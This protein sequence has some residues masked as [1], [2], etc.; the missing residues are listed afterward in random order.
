MSFHYEVAG[1][2]GSLA[3]WYCSQGPR[4]Y[5]L[6]YYNALLIHFYK[7]VRMMLKIQ[8]DQFFLVVAVLPSRVAHCTATSGEHL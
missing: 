7:P 4:G 5:Q 8:S 3:K 6:R 1:V 2:R